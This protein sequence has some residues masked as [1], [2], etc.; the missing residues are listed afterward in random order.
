MNKVFKVKFNK[1]TGVMAVVSELVRSL[2]KQNKARLG[3]PTGMTLGRLLKVATLSVLSLSVMNAYA[4]YSETVNDL[5][6]VQRDNE[7]VLE[8]GLRGIGNQLNNENI[9]QAWW[10]SQQGVAYVYGGIIQL[11]LSHRR[12]L[13]LC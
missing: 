9:D 4:T 2:S 7:S 12:S 11:L 10:T 5:Y 1:S 6:K 3:A 13:S 8:F